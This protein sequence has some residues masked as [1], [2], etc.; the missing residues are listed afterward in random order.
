MPITSLWD[1]RQA[2]TLH[3]RL[4]YLDLKEQK[5]LKKAPNIWCDL[6]QGKLKDPKLIWK[7]NF[8]DLNIWTSF[9]TGLVCANAYSSAATVKISA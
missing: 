7:H 3:V 2:L 6:S 9:C 4:Q 5:F 1:R 8:N